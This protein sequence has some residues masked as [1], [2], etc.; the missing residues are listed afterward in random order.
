MKSALKLLSLALVAAPAL[1]AY[2]DQPFDIQSQIGP[3]PVLPAI[4]QYLF[5]QMHLSSVVGW[6]NGETPTVAPGLKIE[7]LATGLQ[8]PRSLYTLPNGD[9]LVVEFESAAATA[10]HEA[11]RPCHAIHRRVSDVGRRPGA[12]QPHHAFALR[13]HWR[14]AARAIRSFLTISVRRSAWPWLATSLRRQ[15]R[16]D[17]VLPLS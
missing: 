12:K 7:A 2:A 13:R 8:H 6:K 11:Q 9:V 3:N 10:D 16:R 5:P 1:A 4:Q 15:H 17:R 14:K